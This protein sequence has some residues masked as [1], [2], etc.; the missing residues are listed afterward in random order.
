MERGATSIDQVSLSRPLRYGVAF[1][2]TLPGG[3]FLATVLKISL[4]HNTGNAIVGDKFFLCLWRNTAGIPCCFLIYPLSN[5]KLALSP[6]WFI[7][8]PAEYHHFHYKAVRQEH[9]SPWNYP[10][11]NTGG[12]S[13]SLLQWI[14]L[15]Q[16]SNQGALHCRR[17]LYQLSHRGSPRILGWVTY[18]F[19]SGTSWPSNRT[20]MACIAGRLFTSWAIRDWSISHCCSVAQ[21]CPTLCNCMDCSTPGFPVLHYILEFAQIHVHW[22][23]DSILPSHPLSPPSLL[24]LNFS[25]H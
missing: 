22:G 19:S 20:R 5:I 2:E 6:S 13:L 24:S 1:L 9:H 11:Q 7:S 12:G 16:Q 17:I 4:S 8:K 23:N 14:F 10:C 18:P 25:Q 21:S 3:Q 15:T